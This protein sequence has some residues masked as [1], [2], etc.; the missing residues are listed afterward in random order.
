MIKT[1]RSLLRG[2][3]GVAGLGLAG[4]QQL[5]DSRCSDEIACFSFEYHG[6][7]DI[8]SRLD[9][10]HTGGEEQLYAEEVYVTNVSVDYESGETETIEWARLDDDIGPDDTITGE[11][12]RILLG[13][14]GIVKILWRQGSDDRVIEGWVYDDDVS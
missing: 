9:I 5:S 7:D 1:R 3:V 2:S 12:I 4:C 6:A 13:P 11:A 10:E 8:E 14:A